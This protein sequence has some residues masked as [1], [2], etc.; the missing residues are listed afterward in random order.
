MC[1]CAPVCNVRK[2]RY[3]QS[4]I[5]VIQSW[6]PLVFC[7]SP[8]RNGAL[9]SRLYVP[10]VLNLNFI[11]KACPW[12]MIQGA[13]ASHSLIKFGVATRLYQGLGGTTC[14]MRSTTTYYQATEAVR[15]AAL[16]EEIGDRPSTRFRSARSSLALVRQS[17]SKHALLAAITHTPLPASA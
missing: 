9:G 6:I 13:L 2:C 17:Q 12:A 14:V 4:C 15:S 5:H 3:L 7:W 11:H 1:Y 10:E 16:E 8:F